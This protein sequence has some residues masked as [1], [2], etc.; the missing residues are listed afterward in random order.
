[1]TKS[2]KIVLNVKYTLSLNNLDNKYSN[3]EKTTKKAVGLFDYYTKEEKRAVSMYDY[4][5]GDINK[6]NKMNLVLENGKHAS[7]E[8]VERRKKL[9]TKYLQKSNLWQGFVSFN[10]YY[11]NENID[12]NILE[13]KLAT[14][15]LP[16]FFKKIGF[17]DKEKMFYQ[18]SLHTDTDH[19]HFHFSFMER[20][21]NYIY[22]KNK[23]G[24]RR[25]GKISEEDINYLKT[26][27]VHEIEKGKYFTPLLAK[28]NREIDELKKYFS[29]KEK[30]FL[31]KDKKDLLYEEKILKLGKILYDTRDNN[32][33]SIKYNSIN[34]KEIKRL[35]NEI[36]NYIFSKSNNFNLEYN[37]FKKSLD[38]INDYFNNINI[39]NNIK[40]ISGNSILSSNKM[41]YMD[42]YICNA[43]VNF[44]LYNYKNEKLNIKIIKENDII[45]S[46]ILKNYINNKKQS[47]KEILNNYFSNNNSNQKYKNKLMIENS[48]KNINNEMDEAV[49]EFS[50]L[51]DDD[52]LRGLAK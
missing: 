47:R 21:P 45:K 27:I 52:K 1:M 22:S 24:Y 28:T 16:K 23:I 37:N 12:I 42:N 43:I 30:N 34:N 32:Q 19:L 18:L 14:T 50:K 33:K 9:I 3:K 4:Y 36:K 8:E 40:K 39:N 29:P 20:K 17:K 35:T 26:Q 2:P 41:K 25:K 38:K 46:I 7:K 44:S 49:K 15:I 10:N 13:K 48:I 31:L 51:F 11:I 5:V 6:E